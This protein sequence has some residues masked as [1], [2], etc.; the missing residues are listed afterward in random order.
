[1]DK[2]RLSIRSVMF[3]TFYFSLISFPLRS[4][5]KRT[6]VAINII[7]AA[8]LLGNELFELAVVV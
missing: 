6:V 2:P 1:M 4:T 5:S 3:V 8:F 7:L